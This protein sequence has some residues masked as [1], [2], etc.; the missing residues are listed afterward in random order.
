MIDVQQ[1]TIERCINR[2]QLEINTQCNNKNYTETVEHVPV[3][4]RLSSMT[5]IPCTKQAK[6]RS[7]MP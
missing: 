3:P 6:S 1:V 5:P 7:R 2:K 4:K